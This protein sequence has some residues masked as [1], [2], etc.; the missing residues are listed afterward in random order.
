[1]DILAL[2]ISIAIAQAAGIIGSIF[3]VKSIAT[4]YAEL[5]KPSWNPPG[6][7]FAPVWTVLYTL[8]GIAAYLVWQKSGTEQMSLAFA[9]YGIHLIL[10]TLWSIIFFGVQKPGLAFAEILILLVFVLWTAVLFFMIHPVAGLLLIPY[11]LWVSFASVLNY[12]LWR[13]N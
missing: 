7:V 10:N 6:W 2:I 11:L 3:T 13:L 4:W 9:V 1:M 12:T 8:M 5:S